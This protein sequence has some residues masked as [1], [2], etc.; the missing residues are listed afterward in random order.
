[1]TWAVIAIGLVFLV[2][3]LMWTMA[4]RQVMTMLAQASETSMRIYGAVIAVAGV[5]IL[6]FMT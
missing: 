2:E 4:P 6:W 3:G 1:M 5:A